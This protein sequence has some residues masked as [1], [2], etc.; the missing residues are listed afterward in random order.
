MTFWQNVADQYIFSIKNY[1]ENTDPS[2]FHRYYSWEI[3]LFP[4]KTICSKDE[5]F[6][7]HSYI[8]ALPLIINSTDI[9]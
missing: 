3:P 8:Y 4:V 1:D 9:S 5:K 2:Y 6:K 7:K